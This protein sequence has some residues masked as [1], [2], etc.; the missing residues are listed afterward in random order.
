MD[1]K[2][3]S[4]SA[5]QGSPPAEA[6]CTMTLDSADFVKMF[7]GKLKPTAA[8]MSGK[9]KIQGDLGKAMKLEKL[10]GQ[11]QSKL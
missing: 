5:G 8:F 6:N 7:E 3:G 1:L 4:G 2:N 9:L 11:M 10:M